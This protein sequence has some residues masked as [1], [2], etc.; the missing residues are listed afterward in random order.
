MTGCA[1]YID[2]PRVKMFGHFIGLIEPY[3][4]IEAFLCYLDILEYLKKLERAHRVK[5]CNSSYKEKQYIEIETAN[6]CLS[7]YLSNKLNINDWNEIIYKVLY[8]E[9]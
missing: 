5:I 2:I 1:T 4:S 3:Y 8:K 7:M 9:T 6:D